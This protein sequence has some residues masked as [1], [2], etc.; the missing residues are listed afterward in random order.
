MVS[1]PLKYSGK[2]HKARAPFAIYSSNSGQ[3]HPARRY[4]GSLVLLHRGD[5]T[6]V[7]E[8]DRG[9]GTHNQPK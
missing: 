5:A 3:P 4:S 6:F 8:I 7:L 2:Q 9:R 1:R